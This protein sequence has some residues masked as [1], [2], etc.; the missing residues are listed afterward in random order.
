MLDRMRREPLIWISGPGGCGKTT[1][2]G[3]YL[4]DRNI[5]CLWY[6]VD[7]GDK[8]PATFF[9]YLSL[10]AKRASPKKKTS[11]PIFTHDFSH[12]LSAFTRWYFERLFDLLNRPVPLPKNRDLRGKFILVFDNFHEVPEGSPLGRGT[13]LNISIGDAAGDGN[14][15]LL[16][17]LRASLLS[18][19]FGRG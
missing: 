3:S 10:A 14:L 8:D 7:E 15:K 11:L 17:Y 16:R 12:G 19:A 13:P 9:Y 1:L 2:V 6:Q 18:A 4:E 5:P